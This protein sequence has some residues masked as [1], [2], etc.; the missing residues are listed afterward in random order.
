MQEALGADL[1]MAFDECPP[2]PSSPEYL[3][4]SLE[5]T[6]RWLERSLKAKT[7]PDQ[8]LF[9]IA[10]GGRTPSSGGS[11]P[12]RPSGLTS[13]ATHRGLGRGGAQGGHVRHGGAL[14][15]PPP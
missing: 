11:P 2:Y 3:K 9:G 12:W 1:I 14:H 10:R 15:P 4:A 8:A 7:R 6:L 5:R 13:R